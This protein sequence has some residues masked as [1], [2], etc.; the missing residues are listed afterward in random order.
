RHNT[1]VITLDDQ[2]H[3]MVAPVGSEMTDRRFTNCSGTTACTWP[4]HPHRSAG[5]P[6][7]RYAIPVG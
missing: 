1:P 5:V 3:L 4:L 2:V 6:P 7:G